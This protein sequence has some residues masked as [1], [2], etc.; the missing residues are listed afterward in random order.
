MFLAEFSQSVEL[1]EIAH[2]AGS[3]LFPHSLEEP[4][5]NPSGRL[6]VLDPQMGADLAQTHRVR[7]EAGMFLAVEEVVK[8]LRVIAE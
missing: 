4:H 3:R 1:D 2:G 8:A 5:L 7:A 6:V